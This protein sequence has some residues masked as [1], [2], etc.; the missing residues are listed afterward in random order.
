MQIKLMFKILTMLEYQVTRLF[1][2][3]LKANL[4][5]DKT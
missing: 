3:F 1:I 5:V 2:H 4:T